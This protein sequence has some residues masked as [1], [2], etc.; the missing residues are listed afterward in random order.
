MKFVGFAAAALAIFLCTGRASADVISLDAA[1]RGYF[2]NDG[3]VTSGPDDSY[4][5]GQDFNIWRDFFVF[6]TSSFRDVTSATLHL[7]NP[8][9]IIP[10]A[11]PFPGF[12]DTVHSS[13]TYSVFSLTAPQSILFDS[14]S[15]SPANLAVYNSIP[16]GTAFG[17]VTVTVN[18]L[19][20]DVVLD[21]AAIDAINSGSGQFAL[22]GIIPNLSSNPADEQADFAFSGI[23]HGPDAAQLIVEATP[24]PAPSAF[25]IFGAGLL[26][27][28][29]FRYRQRSADPV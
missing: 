15:V 24:V 21:A 11:P 13:E 5:V 12:I 17:S 6:D 3:A 9:N 22:A 14:G 28:I 27:V 8:P 25:L 18:D 19:F 4:A 16:G 2:R 26:G 23:Q 10:P 1:T 20:V 7:A 29:G